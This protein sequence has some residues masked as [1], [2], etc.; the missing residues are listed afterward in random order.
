MGR[1]ST[2]KFSLT[3]CPLPQGGTLLGEVAQSKTVTERAD[4]LHPFP[5][6][7]YRRFSYLFIP[8]ERARFL[9]YSSILAMM[10]FP[11]Y[12]LSGQVS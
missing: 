5:K 4:T 7:P 12:W 8:F 3:P 11:A 2:I 10:T 9:L 1:G 6:L